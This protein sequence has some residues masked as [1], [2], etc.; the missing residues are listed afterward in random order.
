MAGVFIK[1]I[2]NRSADA[3]KDDHMWTKKLEGGHL[4]AKERGLREDQSC[5]HLVCELLAYIREKAMAP[6]SSTL[7]WKIP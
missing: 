6:H 3:Q 2:D 1:K 5:Q 7:A 4:P